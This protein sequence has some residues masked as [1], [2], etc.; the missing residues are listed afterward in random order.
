MAQVTRRNFLKS[1]GL[2]MA[3][4]ALGRQAL[5]AAA[6]AAAAPA[7]A[8]RK[9]NVIFILAD[10][11][12]YGD[13]GCYGARQVKTPNVDRLAREGVRFTDAHSGAAVCSPTRY[14]LITGQY[15]WRKPD[16]APGVLSG[17]APISID[18]DSMTLPKLFKQA[19]YATGQVGKWHLGLGR[20]GQLDWNKEIKPGP[21]E[22]GFD[23]AF[24]IPATGDR[25]P[26]VFIE[27]HKVVGLDPADPIKTSYAG[28]IG[29]EPT[30][31][32]HPELLEVKPSHGHD[33]TIVNGISRIGY[34]SGGKAARWDDKT[35][36]KTI[37]AK[38]VSFI[39]QHK[40]QPFFLYFATHDI[41]VPRVPGVDYRGKSGCGIRGD[42]IE[43]FDGSVGVIMATLE[44]LGLADNTLLIVTSDNGGVLD[45]GYQ[46]RVMEDLNG[47]LCNGA[48]R[49]YKGSL[50]EGGHREPFIARWPGKIKPGS[51]SDE[52]ISTVDMVATFAALTGQKLEGDAGPDSY[53]VL[54]ALLGEKRDTPVR[55]HLVYQAGGVNA[56]AIRKG[57]WVLIPNRG[58]AGAKGKGPKAGAGKKGK[59]KAG[60]EGQY[61][62]G[63]GPQLYNV[64]T[65]LSETQ[66]VYEQ[67]PEIVKEL[68]AL[69]E[70]VKTQ[71]RS[72]P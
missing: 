53:N 45:D 32:E 2:G 6:Q 48:L 26:C 4:L 62:S 38:A 9:P 23:S 70:K 61:G 21:L 63:V 36:A 52:V 64:K 71:G 3:G 59:K 42:V 15:A 46:D 11:I 49:G 16:G 37:N 72:R 13:L 50:W 60:D 68:S 69:L 40:D 27:N 8:G 25:V 35:I 28:K 51:T 18:P 1:V 58:A 31:A 57:D 39:E 19:G 5:T 47:H 67:H 22:L 41:H 29:D 17:E 30:G 66:N 65:D 12:G 7:G 44:R 20:R 14:T 24:F 54:P 34:M 43:E 56:L 10:D 55:D 33:N